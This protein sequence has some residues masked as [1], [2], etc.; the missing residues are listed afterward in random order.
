[1]ADCVL[2]VVLHTFQFRV[3][4]A[5]EHLTIQWRGEKKPTS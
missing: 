3:L 2:C 4:T 1:M 5:R